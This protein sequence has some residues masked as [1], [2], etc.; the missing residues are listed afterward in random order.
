MIRGAFCGETGVVAVNMSVVLG[1]NF[2]YKLS[3]PLYIVIFVSHSIYIHKIIHTL[4]YRKIKGTDG[5]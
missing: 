5:S 3:F 4:T 2:M 1:N